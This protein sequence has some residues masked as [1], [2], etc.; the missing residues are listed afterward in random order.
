LGIKPLKSDFG[1]S[2]M[3]LVNIFVAV[4][5]IV[6]ST[7][8]AFTQDWLGVRP[9][10][11]QT[12]QAVMPF[13]LQLAAMMRRAMPP[14]AICEYKSGIPKCEYRLGEYILGY[15]GLGAD[16]VRVRVNFQEQ[17]SPVYTQLNTLA[18]QFMSGFGFTAEEIGNCLSGGERKLPKGKLM[19]N[20]SSGIPPVTII[21][22]LGNN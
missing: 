22:V 16:G 19:L 15:Y 14:E 20:C 3:R 9:A 8:P 11:A 17:T 10:G 5:A 2:D 18:T 7:N 21:E 1:V 13:G 4:G 6:L 12:V